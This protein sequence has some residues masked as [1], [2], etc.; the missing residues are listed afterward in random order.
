MNV[1]VRICLQNI[2]SMHIEEKQMEYQLWSSVV[3]GNNK[4]TNKISV[5]LKFY[6]NNNNNNNNNPLKGSL[7]SILDERI[8]PNFGRRG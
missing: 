5:N 4:T 7:K 6:N 2:W 8:L 1:I 3:A